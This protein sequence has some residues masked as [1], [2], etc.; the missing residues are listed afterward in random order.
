MGARA[1]ELEAEVEGILQRAYKNSLKPSSSPASLQGNRGKCQRPGQGETAAPGWGT[2]WAER[3]RPFS[4]RWELPRKPRVWA[5]E[6]RRWGTSS[7]SGGPAGSGTTC[8]RA[9]EEGENCN[10]ASRA[11]VRWVTGLLREWDEVQAI[12]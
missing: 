5:S 3:R 1:E 2:H 11:C 9:H 12:K 7:A 4:L 6:V 8:C 10:V